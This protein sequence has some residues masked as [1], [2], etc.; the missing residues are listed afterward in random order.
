MDYVN[1]GCG[2]YTGLT[3]QQYTSGSSLVGDVNYNGD[4][5]GTARKRNVGNATVLL[6]STITGGLYSLRL[7]T[8]AEG[9]VD[10]PELRLRC[11]G[12][13]QGNTIL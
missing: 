1:P 9:V 3:A 13:V 8:A 12:F 6:A 5:D 7:E 11:T 4:D 2:G 10:G